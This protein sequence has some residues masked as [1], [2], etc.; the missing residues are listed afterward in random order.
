MVADVGLFSPRIA[1]GG[2]LQVGRR[3][4]V[5]LAKSLMLE[6]G[7]PERVGLLSGDLFSLSNVDERDNLSG[8]FSTGLVPSL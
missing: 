2:G 4:G 6:V 7:V 3:L 8:D 5:S 1:L